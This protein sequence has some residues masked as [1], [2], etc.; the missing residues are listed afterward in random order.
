MAT[1]TKTL[2]ATAT[3]LVPMGSLILTRKIDESIRIGDGASVVLVQLVEVV[4]GNKVRLRVIAPR[5]IP[6]WR[7][8]ILVNKELSDLEKLLDLGGK[9]RATIMNLPRLSDPAG[10]IFIESIA[11][12]LA[13]MAESCQMFQPAKT[14]VTETTTAKAVTP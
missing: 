8:E 5:N 1:E 6:V 2:E 13:A 4:S 14:T 7:D 3:S 12:Y 10:E 11:D 9:L